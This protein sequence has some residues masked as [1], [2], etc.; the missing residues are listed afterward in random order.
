MSED[1]R[2]NGWTNYETWA[3]SLWMDNEE[4][5]YRYV[6]E[7]ARLCLKDAPDASQVEDGIWTVEEAARFGLEDRLKEE[8]EEAM[9]E[10]DGVWSDLLRG[11][12]SE[13]DWL[14]IARN[15]LEEVAE[16]A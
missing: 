9:P 8:Y 15:V 16:D 3:V 13:V 2:Y 10:L 11:A 4:G 14:E 1:H 12:F 5:S 7:L 6:R